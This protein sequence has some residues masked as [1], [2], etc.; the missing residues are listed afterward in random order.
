MNYIIN[1]LWQ[2]VYIVFGFVTIYFALTTIKEKEK[3]L[4]E[5]PGI[6]QVFYWHGY[7]F[8]GLLIVVALIFIGASVYE[9]LE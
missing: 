8:I 9:L 2:V 1:I 7:F 4:Q 6:V 3:G 5:V